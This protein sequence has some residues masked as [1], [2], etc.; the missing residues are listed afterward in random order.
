MKMIKKEITNIVISNLKSYVGATVSISGVINKSQNLG[1]L[2]FIKLSDHTGTVQCVVETNVVNVPQ[3]FKKNDWI[4][5]TGSVV[6][7]TRAIGGFEIHVQTIEM[8]SE[9]NHEQ[10]PSNP[11]YY[12]NL[13]SI[14][15]RT[16]KNQAIFKIKSALQVAFINFLHSGKIRTRRRG[17]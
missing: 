9:G 15:L 16:L 14:S 17:G 1:G 2:I 12:S 5:V 4:K 6:A 13:R 3:L 11:E 8:L 10:I 7:E